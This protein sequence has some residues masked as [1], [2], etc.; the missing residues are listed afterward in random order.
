M[1]ETA[2]IVFL[3]FALIIAFHFGKRCAEAELIASRVETERAREAATNMANTLKDF[4]VDVRASVKIL[5]GQI[6]GY[7]SGEKV[8]A[9]TESDLKKLEALKWD[10]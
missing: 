5:R 8:L 4:I 10:T 2:T 1:S 3:I 6:D 7:E 9:Q